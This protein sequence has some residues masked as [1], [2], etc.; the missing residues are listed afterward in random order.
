MILL[1]L[2]YVFQS[3]KLKIHSRFVESQ[4]ILS[5][6]YQ[7]KIAITHKN[8]NIYME[9]RFFLKG[10]TMGQTPNN[11]TIIKSITII[12]VYVSR[13][14]KKISYF[15]LLSYTLIIFLKGGNP[16]SLFFNMQLPQIQHKPYLY[17]T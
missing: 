15:S 14:K 10:K 13:L 17:I 2:R 8:T 7:F 9:N 11:F 16:F 12:L 1:C 3:S 6:N 4:I 5:K